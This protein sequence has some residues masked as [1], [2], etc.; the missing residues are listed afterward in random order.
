MGAYAV[1]G[2]RFAIG[3]SGHVGYPP[4]ALEVSVVREPQMQSSYVSGSLQLLPAF[5]DSLTRLPDG[6]LSIN[7]IINSLFN[8]FWCFFTHSSLS[9]HGAKHLFIHFDCMI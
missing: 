2:E 4:G 9:I 7:S 5:N 8:W 1:E 6:V 3:C